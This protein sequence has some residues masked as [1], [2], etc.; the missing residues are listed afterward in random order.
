MHLIHK[1]EQKNLRLLSLCKKLICRCLLRLVAGRLCVRWSVSIFWC[2][3]CIRGN[4]FGRKTR[5]MIMN[6]NIALLAKQPR[7]KRWGSRLVPFEQDIRRMRE[8]HV[9]F[10]KIAAWVGEQGLHITGAA[11]CSFVG[12]RARR[13]GCEYRLPPSQSSQWLKLLDEPTALPSLEL[14]H[15]QLKE[16]LPD[17][18]EFIYRPPKKKKTNITDEDL[19]LNDPRA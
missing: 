19:S 5:R 11:I 9:S 14:K 6:P 4:Y 18:D 10:N 15:G 7:G 12:A 8:A 2:D 16:P 1:G 13:G 17:G 3:G